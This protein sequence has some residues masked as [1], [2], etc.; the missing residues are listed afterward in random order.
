MS[1]VAK[2]KEKARTLE[3]RAQW[4]EALRALREAAETAEGNEVEIGLW[5]RI[6]DLHARVGEAERAVEAYERAADAYAE[7]GLH[8]NAIALCKKVLRLVPG[9]VAV[10]RKL[11][12]L[13]AAKGFLADARQNFLEYA[14][15]SQRAGQLDAS[16]EALREFVELSPE[17]A[18]LRRLLADQLRSF[19]REAEAVEQL[20]AL[21]GLCLRRGEA[22]LAEGL[23]GEILLLDPGADPDREVPPARHPADAQVEGDDLAFASLSLEEPGPVDLLPGLELAAPELPEGPAGEVPLLQGLEPTSPADAAPLDSGAELP[24]LVEPVPAESGEDEDEDED[25]EPLP[26]LDF[27]ATD[28]HEDAAAEEEADDEPL[29]LLDLQGEWDSEAAPEVAEDAEFLAFDPL[30]PLAA[31]EDPL[32]L[33]RRRVAADPADAPARAELVTLLN[34][35]AKERAARGDYAAALHAVRE[36]LALRPADPGALQVQVEYAARTGDTGAVVRAHLEL[37]RALAGAGDHPRSAAVFRRVLELDPVNAEALAALARPIRP[38]PS[39]YVDLRALLDEDEPQQ[40]STRFTMEVEP[41]SGDDDADFAELL[42]AFKQKVAEHIDAEDSSSHYD[43]GLA[44]ME[45]GLV[46]EAIAQFQVA[47][48]G[49]ANPL[50]TLEVLGKCFAEKGQHAVASKVL[51]RATRLPTSSDAELIGVLYELARAEEAVGNHRAARDHLERVL[52]VD[53]RFRD[54]SARLGAL[55]AAAL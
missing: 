26:L 36:S 40:T 37:A 53:I 16:F 10:Y 42:S 54:A 52:A 35:A 32:D 51:E 2:L 39:D 9:R 13:S 44:F 11:G 33:L 19:G 29:P 20:Q 25:N 12:R 4:K 48:R 50:A 27:V 38:A 46:D 7:V 22:E 6:G 14:E 8:N 30:E 41:P 3:G 18:E 24:S 17:D 23:R 1:N 28:E 47:L 5:N 55:R 31:P 15:R 43:L 49:G 34:G 21:R 45:M